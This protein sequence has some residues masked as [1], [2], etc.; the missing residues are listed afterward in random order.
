MSQP[1]YG[2]EPLDR[3]DDFDRTDADDDIEDTRA[4]IEQTRAEM[5]DTIDAIKE[6]LEPGRL[7]QQAK[8]SVAE[9]ASE[10]MHKARDA[11]VGRA[12]EAVGGAIHTA[13]DAGE[14][15][16]DTIKE[17]PMPAALIG[18]GLG[19]LIYSM[20]QR[21]S[22]PHYGGDYYARGYDVPADTSERL[23]GYSDRSSTH[24]GMLEQAK[25]KT[26]EI[27]G[28]VQ[29]KAGE[30]AG[31]VRDTMSRAGDRARDAGSTMMDAVRENPIPAAL[32]ALSLGWLF[33]SARS[34]DR[35][36]YDYDRRG[37]GY[38]Y[39]RDAF[40]AEPGAGSSARDALGQA[41]EKAGEFAE[42]V[43]ERAGEMTEQARYQATLAGYEARDRISEAGDAVQRIMR[44]NPVAVGAA[45]FGLGM[46]VGLLVPETQQEHRMMGEARDNLMHR[47]QE[48]A[49]EIGQKVQHVAQETIGAAKETARQEAK[50]EGLMG[51]QQAQAA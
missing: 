26:G 29:E 33:M 31:Q 25:E 50:N 2:T 21:G 46:A 20:Q 36:G 5:S 19:W 7:A 15:F 30:V 37:G 9:A 1:T 43:Q 22:R 47:A 32:S 18:L 48:T 44:E 17:N 38:G 28:Q 35:T 23:S 11:T 12:Q 3:V 40:Y 24:H 8:E 27:A 13:K 39:G 41:Q 34:H 14:T 10:A 51:D 45:A 49:Q 6:K 42:K 4:Q 16:V